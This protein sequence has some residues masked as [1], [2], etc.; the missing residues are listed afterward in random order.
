MT[1]ARLR[2]GRV[3]ELPGLADELAAWA[4]C[5]PV[6]LP[7]GLRVPAPQRAAVRI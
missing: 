2:Q 4:A 7:T 3:G 5:Y 1:A 6:K